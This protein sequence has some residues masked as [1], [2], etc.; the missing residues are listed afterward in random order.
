MATHSDDE[1][2]DE[3]MLVDEE[4]EEDEEES[5]SDEG[6]GDSSLEEETSSDEEED[7]E[8]EENEEEEEDE[9][10]KKKACRIRKEGSVT[11]MSGTSSS[12]RDRLV[13]CLSRGRAALDAKQIKCLCTV[14]Q[15]CSMSL[16]REL[17][18]EEDAQALVAPLWET[19][20][21]LKKLCFPE[22]GVTPSSHV[23]DR[24]C[25]DLHALLVRLHDSGR[26]LSEAPRLQTLFVEDLCGSS[27]DSA[28]RSW[29][30]HVTR[31][32]T[33]SDPTAQDLTELIHD[34]NLRSSLQ[35]M[36]SET[37]APR[38]PNCRKPGLQ[39]TSFQ[40]RAN[41]EGRTLRE[42]CPHCRFVRTRNT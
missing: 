26:L 13:S 39:V 31:L 42:F 25:M 5:N 40:A 9:P 3:V 38:C 32:M 10:P 41:D 16:V 18:G 21:F 1:D 30:D 27:L 6:E 33:E 22:E 14:Q 35:E 2:D 4:G 29:D 8:E 19:I 37:Q 23:F 28:V 12:S 34:S 20:V 17:L 7:T 24:K 11:A 15:A 36:Q